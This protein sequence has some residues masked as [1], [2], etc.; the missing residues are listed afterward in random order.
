MSTVS[1]TAQTYVGVHPA[2]AF[3]MFADGRLLGAECAELAVGAAIAIP[4]PMR[5]D[6]TD[7]SD[8][9][10]LGRVMSIRPAQRVVIVHQQPWPGRLTIRFHRE[11]DGTRV[12]LASEVDHDGIDWLV[13]RR[14]F[15]PPS[16]PHPSVHRIGLLL[17]KS[18]SAAVFAQATQTLAEM[19]VDEINDDGGIGGKRVELRVGDDASR[20]WSGV[21]EALRLVREGCRAVFAC[22]TSATFNAVANALQGTGVLLIHTVLNEG[23]AN[24]ENVIRLGERPMGQ[25][26]VGVP[27]LMSDTGASRWFSVGQRYSW[28]FGAHMSARRVVS[29]TG[30]SVVGE[31]FVDLGTTDFEKVIDRIRL[32]RAELVLTTLVGHDEVAFQRSF[33]KSEIHRATRTFALVL[34]EASLQLIGD[35]AAAGLHTAFAYFESLDSDANRSLI[36]RYRERA[37]LLVPPASSVTETTYE[38]IVA[39]ARASR[40]GDGPTAADF[41]AV[42]ES[43]SA[44]AREGGRRL[45]TPPIYL[46]E[47]V[48]GQIVAIGYH[49]EG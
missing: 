26:R 43:G 41:L 35:E 34:D 40:R 49:D 28:S 48:D 22:V 29:E 39:Y 8:I 13:R 46:G 42:V 14:G 19:A 10:L 7:Q 1:V 3:Q 5:S 4:L 45:I 37:G 17:S 23:G 18:G 27:H 44:I 25:L 2:R 47:V 15:D 36:R 21:A 11:G 32:S 12:T 24:R 16:P 9:T 6:A 38:A 33:W 31:A 30:G 20:S